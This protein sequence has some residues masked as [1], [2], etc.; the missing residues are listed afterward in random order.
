MGK[1][2]AWR[3]VLVA[4]VVFCASVSPA[5]SSCPEFRRLAEAALPSQVGNR[6]AIQKLLD[7]P[8]APQLSDVLADPARMRRTLAWMRAAG[9]K[10]DRK[11]CAAAKARRAA[12]GSPCTLRGSDQAVAGRIDAARGQIVFAAAPRP[13]T[14][15]HGIVGASSDAAAIQTTRAF[16]QSFG[17]PVIEMSSPVGGGNLERAGAA[18]DLANATRV[19][20]RRSVAGV[21]VL[22]SRVETELDARGQVVRTE[23]HWPRF[24]ISAGMAAN[25]EERLVARPQVIDQVVA[26]LTERIACGTLARLGASILYVQSAQDSCYVPALAVDPVPGG[27]TASGQAQS[28]EPA[29][30]FALL[31]QDPPALEQADAPASPRGAAL[32]AGRSPAVPGIAP[33]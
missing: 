3:E 7:P 30:V 13:V 17:V 11:T 8:V 15:M 1:R 2:S 12:D 10:P 31:R 32:L 19:V 16:A 6:L 4:V 33:K 24:C 22:G 25:V 21:P 27:T 26:R 14:A 23:I 5:R 29:Y 20:V 18:P 9:L 28:G